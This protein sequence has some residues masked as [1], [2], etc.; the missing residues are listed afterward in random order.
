MRIVLQVQPRRS[1]LDATQ[2]QML[3]GIEENYDLW[4]D[5]DFKDVKAL[6]EVLAPFDAAQ[7]RR[8]PVS[9]RINSVT[10]DDPD[11]VIPMPSSLPAQ[12]ALFG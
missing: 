4:L 11:C 5:P 3:D 2:Q 7:M 10:N 9:T 1:P 8:F 6:A 12:S